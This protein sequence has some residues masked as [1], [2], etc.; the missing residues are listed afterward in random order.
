MKTFLVI[1]F[2]FI[3]Y[4]TANAQF[5]GH[6]LGNI[7]L[8]FGDMLEQGKWDFDKE[9]KW[10]FYICA[11]DVSKLAETQK[12]LAAEGFTNF[13]I[14]QNSMEKVDSDVM[15][16]MLTFEKTVN[17]TP[18][19]L[20][21]DITVLYTLEKNFNLSSFDDYGNYELLEEVHPDAQTT[22]TTKNWSF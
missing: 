5:P 10:S 4:T 3:L 8:Y 15:L 9:Y 20:L 21:N 1:T 16:N 2:N 6:T 18:Q 12:Q 14:I 19:N 11:D 17:Y 7:Q 22:A 13:E